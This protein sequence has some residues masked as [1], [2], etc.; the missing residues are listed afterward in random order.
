MPTRLIT[1]NLRRYLVDQ[2]RS[3]RK[4]RASSY[5]R[6]R[7]AH[8]TKLD[9]GNVK[10]D[11]KLNSLIVKH[12]SKK[13]APLKANVSIENG[14]A[15]VTAYEQKPAAKEAL[16]PQAPQKAESKGKEAKPK[17]AAPKPE[18]KADAKAAKPQ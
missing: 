1:I 15:K 10:I 12:Y 14:I 7:I 5:I 13:M 4:Q 17:P 18:Q 16:K 11:Q 6:E 2:P 8:Y 9:V 3:R